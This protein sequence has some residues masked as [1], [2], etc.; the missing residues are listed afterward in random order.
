MEKSD[1]PFAKLKNDKL[2]LGLILLVIML[3]LFIRLNDF[4][5]VGYWNDDMGTVP[6]GLLWFYPHDYYPGLSGAGKPPV[7]NWLIGKGCMMSGEDFSGVSYIQPDYYAGREALLGEP[8]VNANNE[9]HLPIYIF[10]ILFFLAISLFFLLLL[11]KLSALYGISFFAFFPYILR[12]S[13]WIHDDVILWFFLVVGLIFLY[14]AYKSNKGKDTLWFFL[15]GGLFG[16]ATATKFSAGLYLVFTFFLIAEKYF[17]E[18]LF[19]GKKL[20]LSLDLDFAKKIQDIE[21]RNMQQ[22]IKNCFV[23]F[24]GYLILLLAP[25]GFKPSQ[26]IEVYQFFGSKY[27]DVSGIIFN[28]QFYEIFY[29]FLLNMNV[30]DLLIFILAIIVFI[31]LIKKKDKSPREKFILYLT[32]LGLLGMI[33]F[34]ALTLFRVAIAYMFGF[35]L[36]MCWVFS[37]RK[38]APFA[39]KRFYALIFIGIYIIFS[40]GIAYTTSPYFVSTNHLLCVVS[41]DDCKDYVYTGF[42]DM[43]AKETGEY[44]LTILEDDET[45]VGMEGILFYYLRSEQ[46]PIFLQFRNWFQQETGEMPTLEEKAQYFQTED[47][48]TRYVLL[49]P[50]GRSTSDD[51]AEFRDMYTPM[52][53]IEMQGKEIVYIYDV[54][55]LGWNE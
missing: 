39:I 30:L 38:T 29:E 37:Q 28:Y 44:L 55:E 24:V 14:L 13:R 40:F 20:F 22:M 50:Y 34:S 27:S 26:L 43:S 18:L 49:H 16:L 31:K 17:K 33:F 6:A 23:A 12:F 8:M 10:G 42:A 46:G 54:E 53:I 5:Q 48:T 3:G 1:G 32:L 35:V 36:L 47:W 15:A 11:P 51:I 4:S 2:V 41:P 7:A 25:F 45:F 9:C 19:L 52:H 21:E